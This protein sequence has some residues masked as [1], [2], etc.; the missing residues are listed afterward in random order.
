MATERRMI[1]AN[2]ISYHKS[3]F[4]K[5]WIGHFVRTSISSPPLMPWKWCGAS[6][7]F[8]MRKP[9][10]DMAI[11]TIGITSKECHRIR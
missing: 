9:V 4:P 10:P 11:A 5:V 8:P 2:K 3:G 7:A 1:D 6:I